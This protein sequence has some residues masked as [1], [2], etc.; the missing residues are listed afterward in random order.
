VTTV[1]GDESVSFSYDG[2]TYNLDLCANHAGAFHSTIQ[3][4]ISMSAERERLRTSPGRGRKR[5]PT[6]LRRHPSPQ[7]KRTRS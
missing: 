4:L 6:H 2:Y 7:D 1:S 3:Y 5:R